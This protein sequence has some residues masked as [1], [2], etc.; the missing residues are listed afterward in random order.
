MLTSVAYGN[1]KHGLHRLAVQKTSNMG[2]DFIERFSIF[3]EKY[4][5]A[6]TKEQKNY[7]ANDFLINCT[8]DEVSLVRSVIGDVLHHS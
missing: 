3:K 4:D 1:N 2:S 6:L 7:I 5:K 8:E